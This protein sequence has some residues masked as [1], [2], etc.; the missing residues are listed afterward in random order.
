MPSN[1]DD[2]EGITERDFQLWKHNPV[3]K[4]MMKFLGDSR[5]VMVGKLI[6]QW[7][8]GAL[9]LTDEQEGRGRA[10]AL[11]EI[12]DLEFEHIATFYGIQKEEKDNGSEEDT[13]SLV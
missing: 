9:K 10:L 5:G 11:R 3:T 2:I 7:E 8:A 13:G 4:M 6:N 12:K 1:S